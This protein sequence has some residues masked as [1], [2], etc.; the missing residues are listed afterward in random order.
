MSK[1]QVA[2]LE[3]RI[4]CNWWFSCKYYCNWVS[5]TLL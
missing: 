3:G 4:F 2:L 1:K 5:F